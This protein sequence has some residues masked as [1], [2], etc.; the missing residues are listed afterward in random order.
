MNDL[1]WV[2][3]INGFHFFSYPQVPLFK[4]SLGLSTKNANYR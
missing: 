1:P 4:I 2:S 3:W